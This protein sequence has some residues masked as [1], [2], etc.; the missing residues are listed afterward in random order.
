MAF[1]LEGRIDA[2]NKNS[3]LA[4]DKMLLYNIVRYKKGRLSTNKVGI[5]HAT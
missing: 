5:I 2:W 3:T 1:T 4:I